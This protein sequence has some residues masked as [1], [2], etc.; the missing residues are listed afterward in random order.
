MATGKDLYPNVY[1][2]M[3][4]FG[5]ATCKEMRK[6]L[7]QS[8][9]MASGK[10]YQSIQYQVKINSKE[11]NLYFFM[12]DYGDNVDQGRKPGSF[13]SLKAIKKWLTI[14]GIDQD[15]AYPIAKSIEENGIEPVHFIQISNTK[16]NNYYKKLE[17]A[18]AKDYE[19]QL[20]I[21][22]KKLK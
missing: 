17:R 22:I 2:T 18:F 6:K 12:E 4:E 20:T 15:A 16:L 9:H 10:L 7:K 1:K 19:Y 5:E 13:P 8:G 11:Q 21:E 14:K 3:D